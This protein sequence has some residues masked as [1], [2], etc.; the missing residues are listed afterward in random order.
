[1]RRSGISFSFISVQTRICM[2]FTNKDVSFVYFSHFCL[3]FLTLRMCIFHFRFIILM[4]VCIPHFFVSRSSISSLCSPFWIPSFSRFLFCYLLAL[5]VCPSTCSQHFFRVS[6][7]ICLSFVI[8][9]W[10]LF[11]AVFIYH[12]RE[13]PLPPHYDYFQVKSR[14]FFGLVKIVFK[15]YFVQRFPLSLLLVF[16]FASCD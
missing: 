16:L 13:C 1:M 14:F 5:S 12:Q 3:V 15:H 4:F 10:T 11:H 7:F 6:F 8:D 2:N 9:L